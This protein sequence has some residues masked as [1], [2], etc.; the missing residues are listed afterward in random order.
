M[1]LWIEVQPHVDDPKLKAAIARL[2]ARRP[3]VIEWLQVRETWIRR[4][5]RRRVRA[6]AKRILAPARRPH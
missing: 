1:S 5:G 2:L 3:P 4:S 6:L